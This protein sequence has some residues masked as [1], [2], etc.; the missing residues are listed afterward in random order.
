MTERYRKIKQDW[1]GWILIAITVA[2]AFGW[3]LS[4]RPYFDDFV[5]QRRMLPEISTNYWS[6]KT[7][8]IEN[9]SEL[10]ETIR[11]HYF[12]VNGRLA[13]LFYL[14][15]QFLPVGV[16]KFICAV[17]TALLAL[18]FW[19]AIGWEKIRN[20]GLVIAYAILFWVGLQWYDS[21]QSSD[22]VMNYVPSSLLMIILIRE[23][24]LTTSRKPKIWCLVLLFIF[25]LW[26]EGF[27]V[28]LLSFLFV[29]CLKRNSRWL[30]IALG[31]LILGLLLQLPSATVNRANAF[32]NRTMPYS[33]WWIMI[34]KSWMSVVA[35]LLWGSLR[36]YVSKPERSQIDLFGIAFVVS[37]I[38]MIGLTFMFHFP[39][40]AHWPNDILALIFIMLII[41]YLPSIKVPKG[42]CWFFVGIYSLWC[43][44]LLFWQLKVSSFSDYCVAQLKSGQTLIKDYN[45]EYTTDFPFWLM[46]M[47]YYPWDAYTGLFVQGHSHDKFQ[48]L[49]IV[50]SKQIE[51]SP[52]EWPKVPGKN[53][54]R[55][56]APG[57]YICPVNKNEN[58]PQTYTVTAEA[59]IG[60]SPIFY[61][62]YGFRRQLTVENVEFSHIMTPIGNDT[63]AVISLNDN[64]MKLRGRR[65][66][67]V[68][69]QV[70]Q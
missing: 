29:Y 12:F 69:E 68:D 41:S 17:F 48:S 13:N 43:G 59:T 28:I 5:Y 27:T 7:P 21:M 25:S 54:W 38:V 57:F 67:S 60:M 61:A 30:W 14:S 49:V 66:V 50:G 65:F 39:Q 24:I 55:E 22:F 56:S 15:L 34:F 6:L 19:W 3:I 4:T 51:K 33:A 45:D 44:S 10:W 18:S 37:W 53:N 58:I 20:K 2:T 42:L 35:L 1:F 64:P 47:I 32:I 40:R 63:I 9:W 70:T 62:F 23:L 46:G 31:I 52:E 11:N 36:R 8:Y 16:I 26:H